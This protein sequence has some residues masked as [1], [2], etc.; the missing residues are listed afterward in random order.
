MPYKRQIL[1]IRQR[2]ENRKKPPHAP[3]RIQ[4]QPSLHESARGR[5]ARDSREGR[6]S[7]YEVHSAT[8]DKGT[9]SRL[10]KQQES[11]TEIDNAGTK[12]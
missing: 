11:A 5:P 3:G 12:Q 2:E 8:H 1:E 6:A 10:K 9:L 7:R 4:T